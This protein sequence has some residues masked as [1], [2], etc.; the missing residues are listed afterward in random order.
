IAA[1]SLLTRLSD[2]GLIVLPLGE[3]EDFDKA[4]TL[5][6]APWV[7]T[8]LDKGVHRASAVRDVVRRLTNG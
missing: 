6:G 5:H 4:V 2:I 8:A 3:M 7:T 1:S